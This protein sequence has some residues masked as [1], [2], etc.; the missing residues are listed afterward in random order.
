MIDTFIF[1]RMLNPKKMKNFQKICI[2]PQEFK[3][4]CFH[5]SS[6]LASVVTKWRHDV[7]WKSGCFPAPERGDL[8]QKSTIVGLEFY[9][10][11]FGEVYTKNPSWNELWDTYKQLRCSA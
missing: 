5:Q 3:V 7:T 4:W 9:R 11:V 1:I 2:Y 6:N 8:R 10:S